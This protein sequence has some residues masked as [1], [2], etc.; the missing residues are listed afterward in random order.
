M[1]IFWFTSPFLVSGIKANR[2][3]LATV[4]RSSA[5]Q[6]AI[7]KGRHLLDLPKTVR[8]SAFLPHMP[9]S[10]VGARVNPRVTG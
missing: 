9:A 3:G 5:D 8:F 2:I 7:V 4:K 6:Q 1:L 10:M